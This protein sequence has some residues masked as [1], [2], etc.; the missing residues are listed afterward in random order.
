MSDLKIEKLGGLAGFGLPMSRLKSFGRLDTAHL[1]KDE[2]AAV[3]ALFSG[4]DNT[5]E[6]A[7]ADEFRYRITRETAEGADTIEVPESVVP[8]ALAAAVKDEIQ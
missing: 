7:S 8:P 2:Q 4:G 5:G 3:D 1:T 6:P